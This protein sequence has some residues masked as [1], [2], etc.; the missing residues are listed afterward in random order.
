MQHK[1][2]KAAQFQ[3]SQSNS[4][5][6]KHF[7]SANATWRRHMPTQLQLNAVQVSE[8]S[9]PP[10]KCNTSQRRQLN[11]SKM[12]QRQLNASEMQQK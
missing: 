8:G 2:A 1:S 4:S 3:I 12:Q 7:K 10:T 9:S 6:R 5:R 11:A